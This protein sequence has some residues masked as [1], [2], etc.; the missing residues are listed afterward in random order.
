VTA[1]LLGDRRA[2]HG[3]DHRPS[4]WPAPGRSPAG[5]RADRTWPSGAR[6]PPDPCPGLASRTA[7]ASRRSRWMVGEVVVHR[8]PSSDPRSSRRRF[9]PWN[10][11]RASPRPARRP[12]RSSDGDGRQRVADVVRAEHRDLEV[13]DGPAVPPDLDAVPSPS[14]GG[15]RPASRGRRPGRRSRRGSARGWPARACGLSARPGAAAPRQQVHEAPEREQDG[16]EVRV[17]VGVVEL[18]VRD[19]GDV[20]RYLRNSPSCRSTRCRTRRLDDEVAT[21]AEPVGRVEVGRDPPISAEDR[22]AFGQD[23]AVIDVVVV[24]PCVP[25]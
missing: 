10:R 5:T 11:R 6:T 8:T 25:R 14:R 9:T 18:D 7:P 15:R 12:D 3:R 20:R 23:H 2:E 17:D 4:R 1:T 19:H 22:A 13:A 21:R 24:L 16:V